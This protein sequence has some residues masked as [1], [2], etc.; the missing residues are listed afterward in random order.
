[1]TESSI[2]N[3][4][5][6][7]GTLHAWVGYAALLDLLVLPYPPFLVIPITLLPLLLYFILFGKIENK[8]DFIV[9]ALVGLLAFL[10][11]VVSIHI[12]DD[13]TLVVQNFKR[14]GQLMSCFVY[15][16]FFYW[17]VRN[18]RVDLRWVLVA[19]VVYH[20]F[21]VVMFIID[22][23]ASVKMRGNIYAATAVSAKLV[24]MFLRFSYMFEDPNTD[25]Y[26]FLI[27]FFFLLPMVKTRLFKALLLVVA[28]LTLIAVQSLG[29]FIAMG[30]GLA[31]YL[32]AGMVKSKARMSGV[33]KWVAPVVIVGLLTGAAVPLLSNNKD[34]KIAGLGIIVEFL[35]RRDNASSGK[36]RAVRYSIAAK[37]YTPFIIGRG[38]SLLV[39]GDEFR[40]HSDNLRMIIS[41]GLIAYACM[42]FLLF[43]NLFDKEFLFIIPALMTFCINSLIDETKLFSLFLVFLAVAR[44]WRENEK[45]GPQATQ[46]P[47]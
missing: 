29:A 25:G 17:L 33:F 14:A 11:V 30:V 10:S 3:P 20:T 42:L 28:I 32:I 34:N 40:P 31:I 22:P 37:N 26:F 1:M 23:L 35:Q 15:Y 12:L 16:F 9:C 36:A 41:Y 19:F 39:D 27:V 21:L 8:A 5:L 44:A 6:R 2:L 46:G 18:R 7:L 45:E 4:T 47:A 43:R 24:Y 13:S 38:Y